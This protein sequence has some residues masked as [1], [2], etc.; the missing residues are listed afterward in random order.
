MHASVEKYFAAIDSAQKEYEAA[1]ALRDETYSQQGAAVRAAARKQGDAKT[2]E[3]GLAILRDSE[4][5]LT[6]WIA[7]NAMIGFPEH[8]EIVLRAL[9]ATREQL[10]ALAVE[11]GW[12][13]DWERYMQM[14]ERAGVLAKREPLLEEGEQMLKWL[15][16]NYGTDAVRLARRYIGA[17][18]RAEVERALAERDA[19]AWVPASK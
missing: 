5:P 8:A 1:V 3:S 17:A 7:E 9:P 6:V 2:G 18:V 19:P 16:D 11:H 13:T 15:R 14:A 10:D 12:C 4:D